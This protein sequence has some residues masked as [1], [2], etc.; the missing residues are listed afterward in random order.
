[1]YVL[2]L[3]LGVRAWV[4]MSICTYRYV[5]LCGRV[6]CPTVHPVLSKV[7]EVFFLPIGSLQFPAGTG[8]GVGKCVQGVAE[9]RAGKVKRRQGPACRVECSTPSAGGCEAV[10]AG[11]LVARMQCRDRPAISDIS[12]ANCA[13]EESSPIGSNPCSYLMTYREQVSL[14]V[15]VL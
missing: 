11:R 5:C 6:M 8:T 15:L 1:M 7:I 4:K 3:M 9:F 2:V 10:C 13:N 14:D 12:F